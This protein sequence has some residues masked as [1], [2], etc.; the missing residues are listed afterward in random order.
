MSVTFIPTTN[1][2]QSFQIWIDIF[3]VRELLEGSLAPI[4]L[5]VVVLVQRPD[6]VIGLVQS[7][8]PVNK[9]GA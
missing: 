3:K 8:K 1:S 7:G 9:M 2:K 5:Q 4:L 6:D